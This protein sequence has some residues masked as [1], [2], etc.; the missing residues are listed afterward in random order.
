MK[1]LLIPVDFS[2]P[3]THAVDYA[4]DLA[5]DRGFNKVILIANCIASP[6]SDYW[7]N[8]V[9]VW[10]ARREM[11]RTLS[12]LNTQLLNL[13]AR[14]EKKLHPDIQIDTRLRQCFS[15]SSICKLASSETA[16]LILIG[17]NSSQ[18]GTESII[19]HQIINICKNL[20]VPIMIIPSGSNY[21]PIT[22]AVV[23]FDEHSSTEIYYLNRLK[24]LQNNKNPTPFEREKPG[25]HPED[26]VP[27]SHNYTLLNSIL[28]SFRYYVYEQGTYDQ[29]IGLSKFADSYYSQLIIAMPGNK[30]FFY[31]LTHKDISEKLVMDGHK[32][33]LVL[34]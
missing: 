32:P 20:T 13:K 29:P 31:N 7:S 3:S 1:T 14:L 28:R 30:G 9:D 4:A 34:P 6:L 15:I 33:V 23:S 16:D 27:E 19:G 22:H 5:N 17:S 8:Q 21:Q 18:L 10:D 24:H 11:R 25:Y 12:D 26:I 2:V